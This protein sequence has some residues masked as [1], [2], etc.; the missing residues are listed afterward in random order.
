MTKDRRRAYRHGLSAELAA[1]LFLLTKG[2]RPLAR[3][4]KTPLGEI[5]LVV[6][7]GDTIVFAEVKARATLFEAIESL[8]PAAERRIAAAA[9]IWLSRHP[10]AATTLTQRFDLVL[11]TPWR[12]P[13][14]IPDAF[15]ARW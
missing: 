9:D 15:H 2:Y 12:L 11:V 8:T 10:R 4:Y 3:R 5:D 6:R 14:H 13:R 1:A 7:R